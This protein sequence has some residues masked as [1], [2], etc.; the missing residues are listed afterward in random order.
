MHWLQE[1]LGG[2]GSHH[3]G[4]PDFTRREFGQ[5][6]DGGAGSMCAV[7]CIYDA[8]HMVQW[9]GMKYAVVLTPLP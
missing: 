2:K 7:E 3:E 9:Q 5:E 6:F 1:G 4:L 8:M